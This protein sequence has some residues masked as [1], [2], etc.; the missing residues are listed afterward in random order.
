MI[1][2]AFLATYDVDYPQKE[3]QTSKKFCDL[4]VQNVTHQKILIKK[5]CLYSTISFADVP[6]LS[7]GIIVG[8]AVPSL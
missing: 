2:K 1:K 3:L 4:E 7:R 8:R 5:L 6:G